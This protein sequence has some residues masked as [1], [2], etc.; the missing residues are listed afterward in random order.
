MNYF[1]VVSVPG[2][3]NLL[4]GRMIQIMI[5]RRIRPLE[6]PD[7]RPVWTSILKRGD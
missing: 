7:L 4:K 5:E 3:K 1:T 2:I 6:L